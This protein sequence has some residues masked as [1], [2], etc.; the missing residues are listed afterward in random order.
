MADTR[1][2]STTN[3][4]VL[5]LE[6]RRLGRAEIVDLA[7]EDTMAKRLRPMHS[8]GVLREEFLI[9]LKMF[10]RR[11][12]QRLRLASNPN[13]AN[14]QRTDRLTANAALRLAKPLGTTAQ[15]LLN[16]QVQ[17]DVQV[18]RRNLTLRPQTN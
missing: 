8:G 14:R 7:L 9:P 11:S 4:G 16:L 3:S 5:C 6:G 10:G 13:R 18:T 12:C 2:G 15:L 1:S 17:Y